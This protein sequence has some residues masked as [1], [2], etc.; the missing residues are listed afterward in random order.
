MSKSLQEYPLSKFYNWEAPATHS[1][2][3]EASYL[4]E[5]PEFILKRV[6]SLFR[7]YRKKNLKF[8]IWSKSN[9]LK[10]GE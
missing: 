3:I 10:E 2:D 8:Q 1:Y 9:A 6:V 4:P 5:L 7:S